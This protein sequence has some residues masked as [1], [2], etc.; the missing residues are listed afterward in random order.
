MHVAGGT[1][2]RTGG[3]ARWR[4]A[5]YLNLAFGVVDARAQPCRFAQGP[6]VRRM[7]GELVG[8]RFLSLLRVRRRH[9]EIGAIKP[10]I[11]QPLH[12]HSLVSFNSQ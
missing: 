12:L 4:T 6:R 3:G 7:T 1:F 5:D 9:P 8:L 11:A 10:I 2:G